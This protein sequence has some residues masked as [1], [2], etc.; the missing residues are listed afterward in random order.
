MIDSIFLLKKTYCGESLCDVD[1]D[2][3]EVFDPDFTPQ[4]A[5]IPRDE[6]GFSKGSFIV[7]VEWRNDE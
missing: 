3:S 5:N 4:A 7:T 1:R 6:H 2:V